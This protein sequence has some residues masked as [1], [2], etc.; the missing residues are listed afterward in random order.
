MTIDFI[1]KKQKC[2]TKFEVSAHLPA[3]IG[4]QTPLA[5]GGRHF[6]WVMSCVG[7]R[8]YWGEVF[9]FGLKVRSS[10]TLRMGAY[11]I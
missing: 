4:R 5:D 8:D 10:L 1:K 6:E 9:N 11:W 7:S 3:C 2:F